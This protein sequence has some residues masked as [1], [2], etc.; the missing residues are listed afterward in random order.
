MVTRMSAEDRL[1]AVRGLTS[2]VIGNRSAVV[3][4]E[5]LVRQ[6]DEICDR[7]EEEFHCH[8]LATKT[9]NGRVII[10]PRRPE[11]ETR[12]AEPMSV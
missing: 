1:D 10:R 12:S 11:A 3:A 5:D 9:V 2:L 6:F 7:L 4:V 8:G